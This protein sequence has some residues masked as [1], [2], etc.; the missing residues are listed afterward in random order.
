MYMKTKS[1]V[2]SCNRKNV[3]FSFYYF[4]ERTRRGNVTVGD[5]SGPNVWQIK[6]RIKTSANLLGSDL[7][8]FD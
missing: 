8:D 3:M 7:I 6:L 2:Q 4:I 1:I 5:E